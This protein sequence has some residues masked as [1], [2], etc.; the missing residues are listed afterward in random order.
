MLLCLF[1]SVLLLLF[2][3]PPLSIAQELNRNAVTWRI[4]FGDISDTAAFG[5]Y[6]Q[7]D[8][9]RP[10]PTLHLLMV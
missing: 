2:G 10:L 1:L 9:V 6:L 3:L 7:Q 4:A 5:S 8:I